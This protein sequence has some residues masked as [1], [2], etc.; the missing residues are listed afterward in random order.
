MLNLDYLHCNIA[1]DRIELNKLYSTE[2]VYLYDINELYHKNYSFIQKVLADLN[3]ANIINPL[4]LLQEVTADKIIPMQGYCIGES[5]RRL[6]LNGSLPLFIYVE[7]SYYL[8]DGNH[9]TC[10]IIYDDLPLYGYVLHLEL[11]S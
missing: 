4:L 5:I 9:R 3:Y 11:L 7:G 8:E 10:R 2:V 6:T 1:E